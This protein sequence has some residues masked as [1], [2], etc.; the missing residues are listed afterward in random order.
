MRIYVQVLFLFGG[1][2]G[3]RNLAKQVKRAQREQ[4]KLCES[5]D[6]GLPRKLDLGAPQKPRVAVDALF[7][8]RLLRIL[9][10]C[11]LFHTFLP[12][13]NSCELFLGGALHS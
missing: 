11:V 10:M 7:G 6:V 9:R 2:Y 8:D 1:S 3:G 12:E 13:L 5:L 4:V